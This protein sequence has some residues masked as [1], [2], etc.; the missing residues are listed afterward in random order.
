MVQGSKKSVQL[1]SAENIRLAIEVYLDR[2]YGGQVPGPAERFRP[3]EGFDAA[4]WLMSDVTE[5]EPPDAPL[6][7][8]RSFALRIGNTKYPN[9][10]LRLSRPPNEGVFVFSVDSH[11]AFL[12]ADSQSAD[13]EALEDLKRHNAAVAA[14]IL[15]AWDADGLFTERK[16]LRQKIRQARG[17]TG[18]RDT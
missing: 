5:R 15:S 17:D 11:D 6:S 18:A 10:K 4:S 7:G 1:P 14:A 8:V 9:M 13:G 3:P 2:A 12:C 16:F